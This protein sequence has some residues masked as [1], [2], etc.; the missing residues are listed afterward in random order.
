MSRNA[1]W[2]RGCHRAK[3][4]LTPRLV[5]AASLAAGVAT[6][7]CYN[8]NISDP[9]GPTLQGVTGNPTM[10]SVDAAVTGTFARSRSGIPGL[11]WFIGSMGREGINLSDNNQPDYAEPYYGPL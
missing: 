2:A 5:L 9:N 8:F 4:S 1:N 11:I 7:A 6:T 10:I 3:L